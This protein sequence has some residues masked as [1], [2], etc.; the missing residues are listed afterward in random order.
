MSMTQHTAKTARTRLDEIVRKEIPLQQKATEVLRVGEEY[1]GADFGYLAMIDEKTNGWDPVVSTAIPETVPEHNPRELSTTYCQ[2]T[3]EEDEQVRLHDI[4]AQGRTEDPGYETFGCHCYLGTPLVIDG[5]TRGTVCFVAEEPRS[6][7]FDEAE[8]LFAELVT[9][10]LGHELKC[11]KKEDQLRNQA[12]LTTVLN[13]VLRHNLRNSM[14]VIRGHTHK[15]TEQSDATASSAPILDKV[16]R[17]IELGDKARSLETVISQDS[18]PKPTDIGS[19][20]AGV[21]RTV[22]DAIPAATVTVDTPDSQLT[23]TVRPSVERA[24]TELVENAAKHGGDQQRVTVTVEATDSGVTVRVSDSGPGLPQQEQAVLDSGAETPLVHGSGLGL[25]LVHWIVTNHNGTVDAT[26]TEA[27]TTMTVTLPNLADP[28]STSE[29]EAG[30]QRA[31]LTRARDQYRAVFEEANDGMVIANDEGRILDANSAAAAI[32]GVDRDAL[33]GR[34]IREFLSDAV[35]FEATW[36]SFRSSGKTRDTMSIVT[37]NGV[38]RHIE[39]AG[40]ADIVPGQHLLVSHDIT[41]RLQ[42]QAELRRKTRVMNK[43]PIGITISDPSQ[44]DNPLIYANDKFCEQVGYDKS[45]VLGQNCRFPQGE[46]TD[47]EAV[48]RIRQAIA[49]EES[50]TETLRNY[51]QNGTQFWNRLTVAPV[52]DEQGTLSNFVGFQED[53]T[54]LVEDTQAPA[55]TPP[56]GGRQPD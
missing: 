46:D 19:L 27:G 15:L 23:T 33:L 52:T 18:T 26:V 36:E 54:A 24:L 56:T 49:N 1:L 55:T 16:D 17:L 48:E 2:R 34:Y 30:S 20:A 42:R 41:A 29:T 3:V 11:D 51:R 7:P 5:T 40:T 8:V 22:A 25:W 21:G 4:P 37:A 32:Y 47:P 28:F 53:V 50:I 31:E 14:T 9:R 44:A 12:N 43:A 13:R 6:K 35:G 10:M 45:E 38:E 39:Y